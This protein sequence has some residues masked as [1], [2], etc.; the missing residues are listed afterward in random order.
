VQCS[1]VYPYYMPLYLLY[2]L[3]IEYCKGTALGKETDW[4]R[5]LKLD[6]FVFVLLSCADVARES[7]LLQSAHTIE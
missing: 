3:S 4:I 6:A 7:S 1:A 2:L 5:K